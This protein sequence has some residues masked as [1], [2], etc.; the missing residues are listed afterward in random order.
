[1][2]AKKAPKKSSTKPSPAAAKKAAMKKASGRK[3]RARKMLAV[4]PV[5]VSDY[6]VLFA[7]DATD[8]QRA[9]AE[10]LLK[11]F[12]KKLEDAKVIAVAQK[13]G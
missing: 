6:V 4:R 1:M 9:Q 2:A 8:E 3:G 7:C 5:E 12:I 11:Q 10:T 13:P